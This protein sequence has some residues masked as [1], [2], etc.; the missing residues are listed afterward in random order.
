MLRSLAQTPCLRDSVVCLLNEHRQSMTTDQAT[1]LR[2]L[3]E[4][5]QT[6]P[7]VAAAVSP[8]RARTIAVVSGK[9]GVGKSNVALNLAIALAQ[10]GASV[11]LLDAN[12]GLGNI[13]LLCG[14]NG[15]WN[16]SHVIS[17]AR[18][19][20]DVILQG[21]AGVRVIAGASGLADVADSPPPVQ[22]DLLRQLGEIERLC[23]FVILDTGAGIH[24]SVRQFASAAD[25]LLIVTTPEPTAI[26][27]AYATIK[28]LC[29]HAA[30]LGLIVNQAESGRQA[31]QITER[32]RQTCR[33]FLRC[34]IALAGSI[35]RDAKVAEAVARR[36]P[37]LMYS[38]QAPA[39]KAIVQLARHLRSS[40]TDDPSRGSFFPR[41]AQRCFRRAA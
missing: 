39:A 40:T 38:P 29:G 27:D 36:T 35:P 21:P 19:L 41:L 26:A 32:L 24:R 12:L 16:L 18:T 15:Y 23:D 2:G 11:C 6:R 34:D 7:A 5:R 31:N 30:N 14:L 9:G 3:M 4:Q 1:A 17:G 8:A 22:A 25:R 13:D 10:S 20:E 33:L 28:A 37:L